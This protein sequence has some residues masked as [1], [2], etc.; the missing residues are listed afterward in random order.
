MLVA[1][2]VRTKKLEYYLLVSRVVTLVFTLLVST[3]TT[4]VAFSTMNVTK[5][6]LRNKM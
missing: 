3:T 6:E 5:I 1:W 2:T 4:K